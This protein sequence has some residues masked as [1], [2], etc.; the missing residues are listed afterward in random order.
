[1]AWHISITVAAGLYLHV[2]QHG[3]VSGP[4]RPLCI[5]KY[6]LFH[7]IGRKIHEVGTWDG[8]TQQPYR[9]RNAEG[10][11]FSHSRPQRCHDCHV[12]VQTVRQRVSIPIDCLECVCLGLQHGSLST[13]KSLS[14]I[15][16]CDV[17]C[18]FLIKNEFRG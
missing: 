2:L 1:M 14:T 8:Y 4:I 17:L 13:H 5:A 18:W 9:Y 15:K 12:P 6:P 11:R 10:Y 16:D 7:L 3:W